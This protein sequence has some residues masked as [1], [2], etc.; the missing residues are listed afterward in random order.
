M[1]IIVWVLISQVP[2][3]CTGTATNTATSCEFQCVLD[4]CTT[5]GTQPEH[6]PGGCNYTATVDDREFTCVSHFISF[7]FITQAGF[8]HSH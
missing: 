6:C 4:S 8:R 7:H 5:H 3:S 1:V 2:A